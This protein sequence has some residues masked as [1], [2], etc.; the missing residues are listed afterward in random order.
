M[1][2]ENRQDHSFE[3]V[4]ARG[5]TA[6]MVALAADRLHMSVEEARGCARPIPGL[7]DAYL[8]SPP[9][10]GEGRLIVSTDLQ[11]LWVA[12]SVSPMTHIRAFRCGFRS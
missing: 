9:G 12:S 5:L 6:E 1:N 7:A 2:V 11:M 10:R 3:E 4:G 8:F